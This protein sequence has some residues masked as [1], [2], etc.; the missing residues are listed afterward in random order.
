MKERKKEEGERDVHGKKLLVRL[1]RPVNRHSYVF[2][3]RKK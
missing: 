3:E 2:I 1:S